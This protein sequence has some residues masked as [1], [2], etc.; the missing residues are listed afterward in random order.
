MNATQPKVLFVYFTYTKQTLK[1][2]EAMSNVFHSRGCEVEHAAI[3]LTDARYT[4]RFSRVP[5][6]APL[7]RADR[8]DPRGAPSFDRGDQ[9]SRRGASGRLR[10]RL[11]RLAH[12]VAVDVGADP[13]IPGVRGGGSGARTALPSRQ[14]WSAGA[15][16]GHTLRTVK[17]LATGRGGK[18][19]D[20]IHFAY[21]GG[22]LKSLLSLLSYLGSGKYRD[23]LSRCPDPS[24]QHPGRSAGDRAA[25]RKRDSPMR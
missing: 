16:S 25:V 5:N 11:H 17:K 22:Q 3:D 14:S 9:H 8:D 12:V 13:F 24:D 1:L 19:I 10:P 6:A 2:V 18:Y 4:A 23:P 15:T 20:S 21:Q 7:S